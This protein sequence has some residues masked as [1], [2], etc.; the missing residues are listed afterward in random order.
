MFI[1]IVL[2][3][4][5]L[6]VADVMGSE[7]ETT[8]FLLGDHPYSIDSFSNNSNGDNVIL[9]TLVTSDIVNGMYVL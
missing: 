3:N 8:N 2:F 9:T 7:Y 4:F 6:F 1:R 5:V